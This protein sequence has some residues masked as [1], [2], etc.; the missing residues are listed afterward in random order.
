M[1]RKSRN[2][3][4][5]PATAS[6]QKTAPDPTAAAEVERQM[7]RLRRDAARLVTAGRLDWCEAHGIV[8]RAEHHLRRLG[9]TDALLRGGDR[10]GGTR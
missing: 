2:G 9:S 10:R 4:R 1:S 5:R 6:I 7:A 3:R 8:A